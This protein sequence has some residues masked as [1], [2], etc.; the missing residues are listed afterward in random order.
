ML[1]IKLYW[2]KIE[3]KMVSL[4]VLESLREERGLKRYVRGVR[5][6]DLN[7]EDFIVG[8]IENL[9]GWIDR[10]EIIVLG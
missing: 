10:K 9:W 5:V 8:E 6:C 7:W 2:G 3:N 4:M 1:I